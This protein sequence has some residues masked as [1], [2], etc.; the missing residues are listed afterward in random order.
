MKICITASGQGLAS[1]VNPSFGRAPYFLFVDPQSEEV[2][3]VENVP[4]AHGAG[5]QAAQTVANRKVAAVLT[6]SIGPNAHRGLQAA[7]IEIYTGAKGTVKDAI[8]DYRAGRLSHM[9]GPT[10]ARHGGRR[11]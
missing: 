8:A 2:E 9:Q 11:Q 10:G 4:G 5:V 7:G 1:S 3:T 6:G